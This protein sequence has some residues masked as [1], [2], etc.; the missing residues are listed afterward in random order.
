MEKKAQAFLITTVILISI[1]AA[2]IGVSNYSK[3]TTFSTLPYLAQEIQIESEKVMDYDLNTGNDTIEN[4]TKTIS[5]Y[6]DE[7]TKIYFII[8]KSGLECYSYNKTLDKEPLSC[9]VINNQINTTIEETNYTF[10]YFPE[11]KHFYF[12]IIKEDENNK[13][14]YTNN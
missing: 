4:F 14:V 5:N 10:P 3:K 9:N 8:N 11:A 2:F 1:L 7:N 13:Y 12:I 6:T